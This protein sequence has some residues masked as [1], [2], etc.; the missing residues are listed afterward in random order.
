MSVD[1]LINRRR[2]FMNLKTLSLIA[3]VAIA[4]V[5]SFAQTVRDYSVAGSS[6][7]ENFDGLTTAWDNNAPA[8]N[9]W[10]FFRAGNGSSNTIRDATTL[11]VTTVNQNAGSVF[12]GGVYSFGATGATD[13]AL[14]GIGSNSYGDMIMVLGLKNTTG[15]TLTEFTIDHALEQW[16][17]G[18]NTAAHYLGFDYRVSSSATLD[19]DDTNAVSTNFIAPGGAFD[20]FSII[21]EASSR[22]VDGNTE[23]RVNN[24]GGT[25]T[26]ISWAPDTILVLRWWRNNDIGNDHGIA[27]DDLVFSASA[28]TTAPTISGSVSLQNTADD[29]VAGTENITWTLS[30][31]VDSYTG[32][33]TVDDF[34]GGAYSFNIP[35][36]AANGAY[37]LSFDGGTFLKS[38]FNVTLSGGSLTQE[39]SL[40]NGDIDGD[41]EVGPSDFEAVVGQFGG[42]GD[43]DVDNDGEVGPS[44]FEIVIAN[45]G[46]GDE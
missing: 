18:G 32:D 43:A 2:T 13:R 46:L 26:G 8:I 23:G 31:G 25:I 6:Y 4:T 10:S 36:A 37:T 44:D 30:N 27:L 5:P 45:F 38:S 12:N 20:G 28:G 16:R 39:V 19:A 1:S 41:G 42:P 11:A 35:A 40:R 21:N 9:G 24:V 7:S 14:G 34:G 29:G 17:C 3:L 33:F 22:A 15:T